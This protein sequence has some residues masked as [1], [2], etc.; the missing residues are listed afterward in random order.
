MLV[1]QNSLGSVCPVP[2][3]VRGSLRAREDPEP[4]VRVAGARAAAAGERLR[5]RTAADR[6]IARGLVVHVDPVPVRDDTID[7]TSSRRR[8]CYGPA[9]ASGR[10]HWPTE[11]LP[12]GASTT[13]TQGCRSI[14]DALPGIWSMWLLSH[15]PGVQ[16]AVLAM[17]LTDANTARRPTSP[18]RPR[19]PRPS[20]PRSRASARSR[21]SRGR[22]ATSGPK[23]NTSTRTSRYNSLLNTSAAPRPK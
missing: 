9:S 15:V 21:A 3:T 12:A 6:G 18:C 10:K 2:L 11:S 13:P 8:R 4:R 1:A 7:A 5:R 16:K 19:A 20:T 23:A 22:T 14:V 17:R